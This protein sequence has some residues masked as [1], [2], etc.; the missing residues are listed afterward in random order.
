MQ[1]ALGA[2]LL[3]SVGCGTIGAYVVI[4]RISFVAG[5]IAHTVLAG[6]GIAYFLGAVP[7]HG[8]VIAALA[9]AVLIG[10][11]KLRWRQE[12]DVLIAATWSVGMAVGILFIARSPGYTVDLTSYLFGNILLVSGSDL[13]LMVVLDALIVSVVL[14]FHRQFLATA[15]DE[16]FARLRGVNVEFFYIF[17]L[18]IVALTVVLLI[19]IVGL[20]LVMALLVLPA[21]AAGQFVTS[22][23]R[24]MLLAVA[25]SALVTTAGLAT[26]FAAD[27]PAGATMVVAAGVLYA[28]ALIMRRR[29]TA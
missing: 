25:M 19:Q 20:I 4:K 29:N 28:A 12:E 23:T 26:S 6:L 9:A 13:V 24:M 27:L 21:A 10:W 1:Y 3:A 11:I 16:E 8:A 22:V 18:C 5:G 7:L 14:L 15:F 17:L 2:C